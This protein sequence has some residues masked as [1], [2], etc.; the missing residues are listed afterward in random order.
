MSVG[1][2]GGPLPFLVLVLTLLSICCARRSWSNL[3]GTRSTQLS[4]IF[5][6][7][8]T[9]ENRI[10]NLWSTWERTV[11]SE[12]YE[13]FFIAFDNIKERP[14]LNMDLNDYYNVGK[15]VEAD[16]QGFFEI[17]EIGKN[18][19][20][21]TSFQSVD[22]NISLPIQILRPFARRQLKWA[23]TISLKF[24]RSNRAVD[25]EV[26]GENDKNKIAQ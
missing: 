2:V 7:V 10:I 4:A 18:L 11:S 15:A 16:V 19:C 6:T 22:F 20:V 13:T 8:A 1:R 25:R 3:N 26:R 5:K 14:G 23:E 12:G 9:L 21:W 17:R 24:R